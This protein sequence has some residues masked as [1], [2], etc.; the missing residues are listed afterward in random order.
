MRAPEEFESALMRHFKKDRFK[1]L[2][3][4]VAHKSFYLPV[5]FTEGRAA[6]FHGYTGHSGQ[7]A[8]RHLTDILYE[9]MNFTVFLIDFPYHGKSNDPKKPSDLGKVSSFL[10][11]IHTVHVSTYQV[12]KLRSGEGKQPGFFL[13]GESAGALG[14]IRFLQVHPDI[15]KYLAGVVILAIPLEVD[16]NASKWVQKHKRLLEPVFSFLAMFFPNIPVGNLPEGD[17]ADTL[18]YHGRVRARTAS[19]IRNAVFE[20]RRAMGKIKVPILFIH[21][22]SDGVALPEQVEVAFR[23]VETPEDKKEFIVYRGVPHRV[24]SYALKDIE[25]WIE[26]RNET[27]DWVQFQQEGVVNETVKLSSKWV[28]ALKETLM[29]IPRVL[30][31]WGKSFVDLY[32]RIVQKK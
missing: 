20:A 28:L 3:F 31:H 11:W 27:K 24:L 23:S 15:Q 9:K 13:I 2:L 7:P 26:K 29:F 6:I 25:R 32:E 4:R 12:L 8:I 17:K 21:S 30:L 14:I 16:Q 5:D 19:E 1:N 22:D 18:E 10:R